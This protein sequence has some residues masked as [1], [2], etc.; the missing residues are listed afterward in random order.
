MEI[1]DQNRNF[2]ELNADSMYLKNLGTIIITKIQ[3]A[4]KF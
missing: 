3:D 2:C 1:N 4:A